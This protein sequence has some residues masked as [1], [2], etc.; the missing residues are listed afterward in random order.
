MHGTLFHRYKY[1]L[2]LAA[3]RPDLFSCMYSITTYRNGVKELLLRK[4]V[5]LWYLGI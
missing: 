5:I 4:D 2:S 1:I 3:Y